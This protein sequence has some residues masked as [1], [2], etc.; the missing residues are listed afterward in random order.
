MK[1]LFA[2]LLAALM[3]AAFAMPAAAAG[4]VAEL[5]LEQ[6]YADMPQIDVW[7]YP[8]DSDGNC[9]TDLEISAS[10]VEAY[11]GENALAVTG[12]ER[13][14][15]L[16]S[17]YVLLLDISKST[18]T[19]FFEN[20]KNTLAGWVNGFSAQ[21]KLILI[22]MG[23][24]VEVLLDGQESRQEAAAAIAALEQQSR[25]QDTQ[26]YEALNKGIDKAERLADGT[27]CMLIAVS[28]GLNSASSVYSSESTL[29]RMTEAKL[30][31]YTLGVGRNDNLAQLQ[32][33]ASFT[34]KTNGVYAGI[35]NADK[36]DQ[37]KVDEAFAEITDTISS[38]FV[39]HLMA[40][41]N[42]ATGSSLRLKVNAGGGA[43]TL[44]INNFR[45]DSWQSDATAPRIESAELVNERTIK[46]RFSEPVLGADVPANY[47]IKNAEGVAAAIESAAYDAAANTATLTL[48]SPLY[49]GD[50]SLSCI[51]ITDDSIEKNPIVLAEGAN[52]VTI[53][54]SNNPAPTEEPQPSAAPVKTQ[55]WF[56]RNS[57]FIIIGAIMLA[58][59]IVILAIV[60]SQKKKHS[61]EEAEAERQEELDRRVYGGGNPGTS[62]GTAKVNLSAV[63]GK[64][65]NITVVEKNGL[66]RDIEMFIADSCIVGRSSATCDLTIE[67]QRISRQHCVLYYSN[68]DILINDLQSANGTTV[69]GIRVIDYRKLLPNDVVE[70]GN[71][72]LIIKSC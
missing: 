18:G 19:K 34:E 7:F 57:L 4:R 6:Y 68:G 51:N 53:T 55:N 41:G 28:D 32:E 63:D 54:Q 46:I 33:L 5:K 35:S 31:M 70:I 71:T 43:S 50:Y 2:V 49:D 45:I 12:V 47:A 14:A 72:K 67:D 3:L 48:Q 9:V 62:V 23:D 11:L 64:T 22:T 56:E 52:A 20:F 37:Q 1:K 16:P 8:V 42:A 39:A 17:V 30:P 13:C 38:C 15:E 29:A 69:N 65:V 58:L 27:R 44:N 21:D 25:N 60:A 66:S 10:E 59:L 24:T 61:G 26:Y 36:N 40:S